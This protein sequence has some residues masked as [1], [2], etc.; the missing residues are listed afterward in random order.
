MN[1]LILGI[2]I[3]TSLL[4]LGCSQNIG[5]KADKITMKDCVTDNACMQE[6]FKTCTPAKGTVVDP[7]ATI[8]GEIWGKTTNG[9]KCQ[10]YLKLIKADGAPE[11]VFGKDATCEVNNADPNIS[12]Q[13]I[14][15][16]ESCKG[17]LAEIYGM[18]KP[19]LNKE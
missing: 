12:L 16:E 18:A 7:K 10:V 19:F 11:M 3:I 8:Y 15:I 6:A 13:S 5:S 14:N 17:S 1:K 4:L 9:G 2:L